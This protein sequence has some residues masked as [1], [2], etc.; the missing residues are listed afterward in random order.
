MPETASPFD[1]IHGI[2]FHGIL[3]PAA[4]WRHQVVPKPETESN[5]APTPVCLESTA[6]VQE[7]PAR[8]NYASLM[9]RVFALD[10]LECERC[11]GRCRIIAA[12]Q[13]PETT[14]KI[15]TCLGLPSRAPPLLPARLDQTRNY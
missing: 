3:G 10:V 13:P 1:R 11:G 4:K 9:M 15:L 8:R 7:E 5:P 12:I 14:E 2:R 6:E